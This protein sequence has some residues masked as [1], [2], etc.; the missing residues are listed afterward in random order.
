VI[1]D[2]EKFVRH[3][4]GNWQEL[5]TLLK[6]LEEEPGAQLDLDQI[7]RLNFLYQITSADLA[8]LQGFAGKSQL[9]LYLE[10]LVSKGFCEI[11]ET[12]YRSHRL[13]LIHW[14][15]TLFPQ[16]FRRRIR[17]FWIASAAMLLGC[18]FGAIALTIDPDAKDSLMPFDHLLGS[19]SERVAREESG[20]NPELEENKAVFSSTLMTHNIRVSILSMALGA[21][22]GMGTLVLLFYNGVMLGAVAMDYIQA[23]ETSFLLGWLLPHGAVEIPAFLLA[24]QAG[25]L[26]GS[27]LL[28]GRIATPLSQRLRSASP[29]LTTLM[30]GVAL[31]LIWAGIVE[32]FFS[33]I[34]EPVLPYALKIMFG[35]VELLALALFLSKCGAERISPERTP[36]IGS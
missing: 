14:L 28:G 24:G 31:M 35:V 22:L 36:P 7:K 34:H 16:T 17:A 12:R 21:T 2:L 23:G 3:Q 33:Q 11:H 30:G 4:R 20:V 26:L 5:E 27:T 13:N 9:R 15:T 18:L 32:G 29:D 8:R 19:P 25:L 10:T 6:K 1:L